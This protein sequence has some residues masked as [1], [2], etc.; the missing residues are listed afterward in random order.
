MNLET[1]RRMLHQY[2]GAPQHLTT[3]ATHQQALEIGHELSAQAAE[4]DAPVPVLHAM[5]AL[6]AAI[7]DAHIRD[8]EIRSSALLFIP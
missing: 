4:G 3:P 5:L 1:W 7:C 2:G 8:K 6:A